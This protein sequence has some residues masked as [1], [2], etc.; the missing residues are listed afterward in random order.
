MLL[1]FNL[2]E[3]WAGP[4]RVASDDLCL[5]EPE[6]HRRHYDELQDMLSHRDLCFLCVECRAVFPGLVWRVNRALAVTPLQ[7]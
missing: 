2:S 4:L 6:W 5:I 3:A 1:Q 7:P